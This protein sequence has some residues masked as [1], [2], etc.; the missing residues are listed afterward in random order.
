MRT[1]MKK[2]S[3]LFIPVIL[4]CILVLSACGASAGSSSAPGAASASSAANTAASSVSAASAAVSSAS[5]PTPSKE[6]AADKQDSSIWDTLGSDALKFAKEFSSEN[7]ELL[8]YTFYGEGGAILTKTQDK[9]LIQAVFD[10]LCK[11]KVNDM[12]NMAADDF[13]DVFRFRMK[14]GDFAV[15]FNMHNLDASTN[16]Y[17]IE[18]DSDLW[19]LA[20]T[21]REKDSNGGTE[22]TFGTL[23]SEVMNFSFTCNMAYDNEENE[24]GRI[25]VYL[26]SGIDSHPY[27][28]VGRLYD[29]TGA[30]AYLEK[31]ADQVR[32]E[33]SDKMKK[34]PGEPELLQVNGRDLYKI[35]SEFYMDD[36]DMVYIC[37]AE[38]YEDNSTVYYCALCES[39]YEAAASEVLNT[40]I[41]S[42]WVGELPESLLSAAKQPEAATAGR[43][44][45]TEYELASGDIEYCFDD[46]LVVTLPEYWVGKVSW[47]VYGENFS[48]YHT[49]SLNKCAEKGYKGGMLF[50]IAHYTDD[51]Y[52]MLPAYEYLGQGHDGC[53]V[54]VFPT[55]VQAFIDDP[56]TVEE[57]NDLFDYVGYIL[58]N[59]YS[60]VF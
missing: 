53:Y 15:R 59:S 2:K 33:L 49:D 9:D 32:N 4:I 25:S 27:V 8:E 17:L 43:W 48:F 19:L 57:W 56:E 23:V 50:S 20:D 3:V 14:D 1:I 44:T 5:A 13:D 55:D 37:Y 31:A 30:H 36:L 16:Y 35:R 18:N 28:R 22:P 45:Y 42:I 60:I 40:A 6:P 29:G 11:I 41:E 39:S 26:Y 46:A 51:S 24:N 58:D 12:T 34:D 21:I 52:K 10:V 7:C 38:D 54:M 47:E